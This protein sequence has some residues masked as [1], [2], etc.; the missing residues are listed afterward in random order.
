MSGS[1]KEL[2]AWSGM[3]LYKQ[4]QMCLDAGAWQNLGGDDGHGDWWKC[5]HSNQ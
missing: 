5:K 2:Q 4:A 1:A 3:G